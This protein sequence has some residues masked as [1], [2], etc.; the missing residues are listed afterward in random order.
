MHVCYGND[1][2]IYFVPCDRTGRQIVSGAN[3]K[4]TD[5]FPIL[6]A[7]QLQVM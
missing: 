3:S 7:D 1:H 5:A 6:A 4:T 2:L